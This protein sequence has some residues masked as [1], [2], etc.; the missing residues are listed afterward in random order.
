METTNP[1]RSNFLVSKNKKV[2]KEPFIQYYP[3]QAQELADKKSKDHKVS[4]RFLSLLYQRLRFWSQY[5]KYTF[6][7]KRF[8]WKSAEE[9]SN[10]LFASTKQIYRGLKA[11]EELGL[12]ERHK[13]RKHQYNHTYFYH[14]PHSVHTKEAA[15]PTTTSSTRR[16]SS[17]S[18]CSSRAGGSFHKGRQDNPTTNPYV[19]HIEPAAGP[20]G[21]QEA[22]E[23]AAGPSGAA[24]GGSA[25]QGP[26]AGPSGAGATT[27]QTSSGNRSFTD[28]T[29]GPDLPIEQQSISNIHLRQIVEKCMLIGKYGIE[30]INRRGGLGFA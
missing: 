1:S 29:T 2:Y 21:P 20:A 14:L 30:N 7:G 16:T 26:T 28:R 4:G 6:Q 10:E 5:S 19:S 12:I 13:L 24:G 25:P 15:A 18:N 8:F 9:L 22:L 23:P 3:S 11:L 27:S 17:R